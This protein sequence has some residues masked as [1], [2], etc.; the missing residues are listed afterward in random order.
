VRMEWKPPEPTLGFHSRVLS[1]YDR[2][3]GHVPWWWRRSIV[4]LAVAAGLLLVFAMISRGPSPE[5]VTRY[6]PAQ[7]PRFIIVSQGEHP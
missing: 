3:F 7:Q 1:A 6:E 4:A 5:R 2:E